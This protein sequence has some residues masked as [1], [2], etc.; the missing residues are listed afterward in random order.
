MGLQGAEA[1]TQLHAATQPHPLPRLSLISLGLQLV[2]L[3][4][5]LG[6]AKEMM[7]RYR[8]MLT[9]VKSAVTRNYSEKARRNDSP[10]RPPLSRLRRLMPLA[11][12]PS[13]PGH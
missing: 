2:K 13:T 10:F 8:E 3:H 6:N 1:G 5:K 4:F 12:A 7:E 11:G 9:F